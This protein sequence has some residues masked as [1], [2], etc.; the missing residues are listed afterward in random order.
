MTLSQSQDIL[1]RMKVYDAMG[2]QL[3][4]LSVADPIHKAISYLIKFK[5]NAL[6]IRDIGGKAIGVVS[7]TDIMSAYYASL[8]I[9]TPL[10]DITQSPPILCHESDNLASV[11]ETMREEGI[12]RIYVINTATGE[13]EGIL[14]YPDIVGLLYRLCRNCE[15]NYL[16][17]RKYGIEAQAIRRFTVREVM[18]GEVASHKND[19]TLYELIEGLSAYRFGAVLITDERGRGMGVVSKTDL[20][21]AYRHGIPQETMARGVM[22]PRV[23][24]C[25]KSAYLAEAIQRM[26]LSD[27]H[28]LFVHEG[29]PGRIVGVLSFTDAAR[30][31][32]GSCRACSPS[33]IEVSAGR[34]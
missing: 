25:S 11:M 3:V 4:S 13:V 17:R 9:E 15:N 6:L 29:E 30:I 22:A 10:A 1:K 16:L 14:S 8:S 32:S 12:H 19:D 7:K 20:I 24:S 27:V 31:R 34:S 28:R 26:I 21:L 5:M 2:R 23:H 33:R 18:T